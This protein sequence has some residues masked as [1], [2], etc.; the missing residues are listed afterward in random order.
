M[1]VCGGGGGRR[2][3]GGG[4]GG[5]EGRGRRGGGGENFLFKYELICLPKLCNLLQGVNVENTRSNLISTELNQRG[6]KRIT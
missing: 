1:C 6:T 5:G 2:G 3:G 4:E